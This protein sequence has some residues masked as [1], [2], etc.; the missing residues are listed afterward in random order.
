MRK[1]LFRVRVSGES[2][3][4]ALLPGR[5]YWASGWLPIRVGDYIVFWSPNNQTERWIKRVKAIQPEGY[6]VEG[7]VSWSASSEMIG[8]VPRRAVL[9]KIL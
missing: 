7:L 2:M 4:P 5:A 6:V 8:T 3:Y 1:V 9:G